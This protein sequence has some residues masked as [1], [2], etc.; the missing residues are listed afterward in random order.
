[1]TAVLVGA[2]LF[3]YL[4]LQQRSRR[5]LDRR[6]STPAPRRCSPRARRRR[7]R[8]AR[9]RR[10]SRSCCGRTARVIDSAGGDHAVDALTAPSCGVRP[11]ARR[12]WWSARVPGIDG[13]ARV[14]AKAGAGARIAAVGPVARR[15]RRDARQPGGVVRHRRPDRGPP[16]LAARL[17][18]GRRRAAPGRRD[19]PACAGGLAQPRATSG[20]RCRRPRRD[21]PPRGD[22]QRDARPSRPGIR[23]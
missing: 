3:V 6:A 9:R 2:G 23:A 11:P 18:A 8:P 14:L 19:A 5:E 12:S 1:M 22:A 15:S 4:R 13:T 17:H 20:S 16:R 21:P 7:A 10:A